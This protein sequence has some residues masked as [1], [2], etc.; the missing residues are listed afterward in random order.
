MLM[1]PNARGLFTRVIMQS[2]GLGRGFLS[3]AT[4][5]GLADQFLHLLDI[6]PNASDA[7]TNLRAI[8]LPRLLK[9]Q[10]DLTQANVRFAET[11]PPFMPVATSSPTQA[12][13]IA[14]LA[15]GVGRCCGGNLW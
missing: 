7:L 15:D 14:A 10:G 6:D 1:R 2:C 9:A 3:S 5:T 4:A 12:E 13:L 11:A 8:E